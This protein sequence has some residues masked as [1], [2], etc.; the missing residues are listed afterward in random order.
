M[1]ASK[2]RP[3]ESKCGRLRQLWVDGELDE[4]SITPEFVRSLSPRELGMLG[5]LLAIDY[6][7]E[8]GYALLEHGYRCPEGEADLVLF[9]ELDD[10]VVMAE[11]K[12]RRV[13]VSDTTR[14]FPEEA[15]TPKKQKRYRRIAACYLMDR[16]PVRA[17]RF[18]AVGVTVRDGIVCEIEH[19]I[20]AFDWQVQ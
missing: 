17:I 9:D 3:K 8:R 5:E 4:A 20:N 2:A 7:E 18:D 10:L 11:V 19:L 1:C 6:F 12:T 13:G 14:V 15:V 16:Y